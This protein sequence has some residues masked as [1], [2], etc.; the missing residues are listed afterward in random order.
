MDYIHRM[1]LIGHPPT[2]DEIRKIA[3]YLRRSRLLAT[4]VEIT[5]TSSVSSS[6][7]L[8]GKNWINKFCRRHPSV[9]LTWTRALDT[10]R[11]DGDTLQNLV[12][13]FAELR[14]LYDRHGYAPE[15]IYN[16]EETGFAIGSAQ[17]TC[18]LTVYK[19]ARRPGRPRRITEANGR[20][21]SNACQPTAEHCRW[22]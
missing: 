15:N 4:P 9:V 10:A 2:H 19:I 7:P 8:L 14:G 12:A 18:V 3:N 17:S 22:W 21:R 5:P 6:V 1:S 16:M 13:W 20:H 11:I